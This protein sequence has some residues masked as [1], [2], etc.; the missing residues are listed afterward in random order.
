MRTLHPVSVNF[1]FEVRDD[2]DPVEFL[3]VIMAWLELYGDAADNPPDDITPELSKVWEYIYVN[4][5]YDFI[6]RMMYMKGWL[7]YDNN[8][9]LMFKSLTPT[10][11]T[12]STIIPPTPD[13]TELVHKVNVLLHKLL[14]TVADKGIIVRDTVMGMRGYDIGNQDPLEYIL[15][16]A[17]EMSALSQTLE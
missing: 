7:T 12:H 3:G 17:L 15:S 16:L 4:E 2:I 6:L 9:Y 8:Y 10:D 5:M 13:E 14:P 11:V 1:E